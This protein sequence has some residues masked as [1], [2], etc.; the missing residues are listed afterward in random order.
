MNPL[1]D[2]REEEE[3]LSTIFEVDYAANR[4]L[5]DHNIMVAAA[6]NENHN[7]DGASSDDDETAVTAQLPTNPLVN[8]QAYGI[9]PLSMDGDTIYQL[10]YPFESG[11]DSIGCLFK[12]CLLLCHSLL[13]G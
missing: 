8:R 9:V 10:N 2:S 11:I 4:G 13:V 5:I 6:A 1:D 12:K 3:I 7:I